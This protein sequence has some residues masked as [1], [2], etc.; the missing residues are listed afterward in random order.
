MQSKAP[1][2]SAASGLSILENIIME[3]HEELAE[4][5]KIFT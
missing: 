4:S 2:A 5:Q 3:K 1:K